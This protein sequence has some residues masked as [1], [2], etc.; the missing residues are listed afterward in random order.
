MNKTIS[1]DTRIFNVKC[2]PVK[3]TYFHIRAMNFV[4][5]FTDLHHILIKFIEYLI[6]SAVYGPVYS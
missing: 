1:I 2:K 4:L 6:E 3:E 5:S